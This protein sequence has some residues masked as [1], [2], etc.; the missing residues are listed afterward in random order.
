MRISYNTD[1]GN[2]NTNVGYGVAGYNIITSLQS[3]GHEVPFADSTAPVEIFFCQPE[4]WWFSGEENGNPDQY[5]IGYVPWESTEIPE[6]WW[7]GL[8]AVDEVWTT[9]QWCK[10]A[11]EAA[12]VPGPVKVFEHGL[13]PIWKPVRRNVINKFKFLHIGE[14]AP[15][16]G[17][18][19]TVRAFMELFEGN[20]QVELTLKAHS[21][22]W[23]RYEKN[24]RNVPLSS[25]KNI[26]IIEGNE[27]EEQLLAYYMGHHAFVYPSWGEGFG[28]IP[29][30]ALGTGM[31]TICTEAWAPYKQFLSP[32]GVDSTV[33]DS[34]WNDMHPGKMHEPSLEDLKE[35][36]W[37]AYTDYK[38]LQEK[39]YNQAEL[40]HKHYNWDRLTEEAFEP[41]VKK[42][43]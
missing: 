14:P 35:K 36:M 6:M 3:L 24:G 29:L 37:L 31:P 18:S 15:R 41:I 2:L 28:F 10:E 40:V 39:F 23:A 12:G 20:D 32:L 19:L 5:K 7:P 1:L 9:S 25:I 30:Q 17:G 22:C 21:A 34:P 4:Y 27:P 42:F 26:N 13:D 8:K 11:F 33:V 38:K 16:K 43:S